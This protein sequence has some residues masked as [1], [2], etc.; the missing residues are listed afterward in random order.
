MEL[1]DNCGICIHSMLRKQVIRLIPCRHLLHE[2]C[3]R[4]QLAIAEM[5]QC[6]VC[7]QEIEETE[8]VIRKVYKKNCEE[9]RKRIVS[10]ANRGEDW[11]ALCN[12]LNVNYK[13]AYEWVR[14]GEETPK[15]KGGKKPK[16]L[17]EEQ[18]DQIIE[19]V[20][21]D[22]QISLKQIKRKVLTTFHTDIAIS[23]IGNY[24]EGRLCRMKTVHTEPI[25]MNSEQNKRL[26][27][28]YVRNLNRYI[29]EGKQI[30][31]FD[32][33]NFNLFC[34]RK[35][36]RAKVGDRAIQTLPAS[37]G[38]NVH[39]ICAISGAGVLCMERRRGSFRNQT[40]NEWLQTMLR[41]WQENGNELKDLVVVVDNA[42]CHSRLED[43]I[44]GTD[45]VLLRLAPYSPMLNPVETI[46]SKIKAFVKT[47]LRVPNVNPPGV[48]EQRL[49]YL[50]GIVDQAMN[51]IV[52]GD[53]ARAVQHTSVHHPAALGM[54]N[55]QVGR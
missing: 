17:S 4:N 46:W 20:E 8:N 53:C 1:K 7:R 9:D 43:V 24:L 29:Q 33:T 38:P 52:G 47:N 6:H 48:V 42:P 34:R 32:E 55:M 11:V 31:W 14:S 36:G 21:D 35:R 16:I 37:K 51:T 3:Y 5:E 18:I 2:K 27:A 26:R 28:E 15:L 49:V 40:A 44:T 30:V 10:C 54:D 13:T 19:W 22:C 45:A 12:Q 39:L 41:R 23:T 25:T 50:E